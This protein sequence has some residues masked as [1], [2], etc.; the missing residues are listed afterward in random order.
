MLKVLHRRAM[1]KSGALL[2]TPG[3]PIPPLPLSAPRILILSLFHFHLS[4]Q[5]SL[6]HINAITDTCWFFCSPRFLCFSISLGSVQAPISALYCAPKR[7]GNSLPHAQS[8]TPAWQSGRTRGCGRVRL[9][10]RR[11]PGLGWWLWVL[12][13]CMWAIAPLQLMNCHSALPG[14][15]LQQILLRAACWQKGQELQKIE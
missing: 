2:L 5:V 9:P 8:R 15:V 4:A 11:V 10:G 7:S 3:H 13:R 12:A 1:A 6:V 14:E